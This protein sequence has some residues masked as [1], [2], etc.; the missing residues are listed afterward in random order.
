MKHDTQEKQTLAKIAES[1]AKLAVFN[2]RLAALKWEIE[3]ESS[4]RA[5]LIAKLGH[6]PPKAINGSGKL[7]AP[8]AAVSGAG[9]VGF[10]E[11]VRTA[12]RGKA[13]MPREVTKAILDSGF[14]YTAGTPLNTR[15]GNELQRL[16]KIGKAS[17]NAEG[18][19]QLAGG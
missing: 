4:I 1:D 11:A 8:K 6:E 7:N 2:Q 10:A 12:L 9:S 16:R 5:A 17:R 3:L 14:Q 13:L 18:R 19:Y 15:V